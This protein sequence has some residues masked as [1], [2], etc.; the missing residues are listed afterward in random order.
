MHTPSSHYAALFS[1]FA[2]F[3]SCPRDISN[4]VL[5]NLS[6]TEAQAAVEGLA[7]Q[8]VPELHQWLCAKTQEARAACQLQLMA[9]LGSDHLWVATTSQL[10][11]A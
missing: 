1:A 6:C 4:R 8:L 10:A 2:L 5:F 11:W 9:S 7:T 3:L